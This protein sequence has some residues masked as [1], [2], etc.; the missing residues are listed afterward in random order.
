MRI[1]RLITMILLALGLV[2]CSEET[3]RELA[4]S[5]LEVTGMESVRN[6]PAEESLI[7]LTVEA[8]QDWTLTRQE[9]D[10]ASYSRVN[11]DAGTPAEVSVR[12]SASTS[13]TARRAGFSIQSGDAVR[14][15]TIIQAAW[16]KPAE[17]K[18]DN[19]DTHRDGYEFFADDFSW[20]AATWDEAYPKY[21]WVSVKS[22]GV[23]NNEYPVQNVEAAKAKADEIGYTYDACCYA[24]AEGFVKLGKSAA[25]GYI[26]TPALTGID[27]EKKAVVD[28]AFNAGLYFSSA[29]VADDYQ[30]IQVS[31]EGE[32]V[33]SSVGTDNARVASDR[34]SVEIPLAADEEH[35]W[36][37]T[38]KHVIVEDADN[39]TKIRF[40]SQDAV[41]GRC[42]L[43]DI[44]IVRATDS[45]AVAEADRIVVPTLDHEMSLA[46]E[47]ILPATGGSVDVSVRVNRA[48]NIASD[49][50]WLTISQVACGPE[51]NVSVADN[52][53]SA[54]VPGTA[55]PYK[56]VLV[57]GENTSSSER[58]ASLSVT[59]ADGTQV[60]VLTV[61]Q[62]GKVQ[63]GSRIL[64]KWSFTG[65]YSDY[66][67]SKVNYTNPDATLY[68]IAQDWVSGDH[69]FASD[70]VE[71]GRLTA[72][73]ASAKA[74]YSVGTGAQNKD[75]LRIKGMC[76][77]DCFI[78]SVDN[79]SAMSGNILEF[80]GVGVA[81]T[82]VHTAPCEF[83]EEYSLDG[84][85]SWM[86]VRNIDITTAGI[87]G[88]LGCRITLAENLNGAT[89]CLR[90]RVRSNNT[91]D[92][93]FKDD[94]SSNIAML[95]VMND[96]GVTDKDAHYT[97][98][99]AYASFS[100]IVK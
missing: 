99:W 61:R 14:R 40:G 1:D 35:L 41:K 46:S 65:L 23:R 27:A 59:L 48:W 72:F 21:G 68:G 96:A 43:D 15:F 3:K 82:N 89:V 58:T 98:D 8:S 33:I 5:V 18:P 73:T 24:K 50:D 64:A 38:R 78:F 55:L 25:L 63:S 77:D 7:V 20:I 12:I 51:K 75:R 100:L 81:N 97:D 90:A 19:S 91:A 53:L 26:R 31:I 2:S 87:P 62:A 95:M 37:W 6:V 45:G 44:S 76:K 60:G 93:T 30:Y 47:E 67:A 70:A 80:K 28:V 56:A 94:G 17:P 36:V 52:N 22:D 54:S 83:V 32:G 4:A 10:W 71:G 13:E 57:A 86:E 88:D 85:A 16:E 39:Q 84:G 79:V 11:G 9:C 92:G 29:K 66:T 34:K 49:S 74:A 69:R 42:F